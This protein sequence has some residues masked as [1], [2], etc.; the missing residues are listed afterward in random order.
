MATL[1]FG[2]KRKA[3]AALNN[4]V[5]AITKAGAVFATGD[6]S[7]ALSGYD[8]AIQM[9]QSEDYRPWLANGLIPEA[10]WKDHLASARFGKVR[11]VAAL[12]PRKTVFEQAEKMLFD[13]FAAKP[14]WSEPTEFLANLAVAR[15]YSSNAAHY[16]DRL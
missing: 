12:D 7:G 15:G 6:H 1:A 3:K 8:E 13:V 9:L 16:I 2:Q 11:A 4:A 10:V 14:D 5:Q